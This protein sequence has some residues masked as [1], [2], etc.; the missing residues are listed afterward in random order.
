[1][2]I[3][4][5][6]VPEALV[7]AHRVGGL[8]LFVGAG[9]SRDAPSGLP[10]FRT[11]T[12]DIAA[13]S[14]VEPAEGRLDVP[15]V[16]LGELADQH[17]VDVHVRVAAR[18]GLSSSRPN[19][20][21]DAIVA[22]A[23]AGP[24]IRIVTTNY[25]LHLSAVLA[26]RNQS[27]PEYVAPALPMGDDF[28]GLVYLH[29]SLCQHPRALVV[30]DGDFG[31][32]YLRDAWATR[33]LERMFAKYT[34]LFV[35]YSHNDV[36]MV[37]LARALGPETARYVLTS[38]PEA[39]HWRRLRIRP[40]GYPVVDGSHDALGEAIAGWASRA[41]MG[42]LD[43]RQRVAQLV[44]TTPSQVP[45]EASY[46]EAVITDA[47]K[48]GFFAEYAR[49]A[50]WLLWAAT[51]DELRR[52]FDLSV[53]STGC[54]RILAYWFA[55]HF[56]TKEDLTEAALG[57]VREAGGTLGPALWSAI[58]HHMHVAG[59]PRAQWLNP[60]LVL[61][62][63]NAPEASD[64]GL[65]YALVASRW[66]EDR[67][68]ALLLFDY[69]TEPQVVF[70]RFIG[71]GGTPRFGVRLR[72][73][74]HWL[75]EAWQELFVPNLSKAAPEILI[76]ADRHLRRVYQ[77]LVAAGSASPG[78]DP[79]SFRRSAIDPHPQD[80]IRDPIDILIDAARDCLELLLDSGDALSTTYLHA[81]AA[82]EVPLLRRLAVHGWAHRGDIDGSA[83]LAWLREHRGLFDHQLRHEVFRLIEKALPDAGVD[84]ADALVADVLASPNDGDTDSEQQAYVMFTALA[85]IARH[86]PSLRSACD[87]LERLKANHP[88]F[89][90]RPHPDL[91]SWVGSGTKG[92]QPPMAAA[93]L[94]KL[95]A[96]DA[97]TAIEE[98]R[99]YEAASSPFDGPTW[100]DALSVLAE[101]VRD[102]PADG[103]C[104]LDAR[105]GD[106]P[107]IVRAVIRGWA[108][109]I[110]DSHTAERI[111]NRLAHGVDLPAV[112]DD[113]ARL[114]AND[115][116]NEATSTEWHRVPAGRG[117]A[118]AVW[119][120][121]DRDTPKVGVDEWLHR[122]INQAAGRLAMFWVNAVAADWR[123]A[124]DN[125]NGLPP[126][127]REQL[128]QLLAGE[129]DP[130]T[131]AEVIFASDVFFFFGA[132]RDWCLQR[133]LPLLDW[134]N[135]NRA[136]RTWDGFLT[137]GRW[138]DHLLSAGLLDHYLAAANHT[139]ELG[140]D[141][142]RRLC[143]HLAEV[144]VS[145]DLD[146]TAWIRSFTATVDETMRTEWMSQVAWRLGQLPS[147]AVE[148]QWQRWIRQYWTDRR[149]SIPT[150]L[151]TEEHSTMASSWI[152]YLTESLADGVAL[153]TAQP[154]RLLTRPR[155]LHD[156]TEERA[157]RAP[158][159]FVALLTH[160]LQGTQQPFYNCHSLMEAVRLLRKH[161]PPT[162]I[163]PIIEHAVRLAC[164]DA[165]TWVNEPTTSLSSNTSAT[166]AS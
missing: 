21:H 165:P 6:D 10:D 27:V 4:E 95:I 134:T 161:L 18:L 122:A 93:D 1:M 25:D 105:G 101:A 34:V 85:W 102:C 127:T 110:V 109:A 65:D 99:R 125:W 148:Y 144:A 159:S 77:L 44:S 138:N 63:Q 152:V 132:D 30:T 72:G 158:D 113:L 133:V 150:I 12:A 91:L 115:G 48:V 140:Q 32:A 121:L 124:G 66:P 86:A 39:A 103:F 68:V 5:V 119:A 79:V 15:D 8:V 128:E 76:I 94:H 20:L 83:K 118:A 46:L 141:D 50:E 3:R 111:M 106:L 123:E 147:E 16:L 162:D 120:A 73:H 117:L 57:V 92:R 28:T 137:W 11:L 149:Q 108:A 154:G 61:M 31:R 166:A 97:A 84:V 17:Q 100:S 160:L 22:L 36:V 29:G 52:L 23:T 14:G 37:Y 135:H 139:T 126:E 153:A 90:E 47:E 41:S 54:T 74:E 88:D 151:T 58:G 131:L 40:I 26:T 13:E 38:D 55:E 164:A 89:V 67:M 24:S 69:L 71:L 145:S 45:E 56:V 7:S 143:H 70:E 114:L 80:N 112:A 155:L 53:T 107:D 87:A 130:T 42:L 33:F 157:E 64:E 75:R 19:R 146:P 78:W 2:W 136:I 9:A 104:V 142:R 129:D 62:I 163:T 49:G 116:P 43:H 98:L 59:S 96:Q 35:G 82:S 51:Q 81:W 60:W 156:L